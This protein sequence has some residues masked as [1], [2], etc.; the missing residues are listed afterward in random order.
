MSH[1]VKINTQFKT[2]HMNAFKRALESF[3]WSLKENAKIRTYQSDEARNTTYPTIM[4][5][6]QTGYDIG[7]KTNEQTGEI[8]LFG[9]F[10][11]GSIARTLGSNVEKLKQEYSACVIEDK[12][13]YEGYSVERQL[14]QETG[15]LDIVAEKC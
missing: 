13:A 7:L 14:N 3:G 9:D 5:N 12:L 15:M 2:E 11:D 4:V 10:Y 6:P 1:T 8:E